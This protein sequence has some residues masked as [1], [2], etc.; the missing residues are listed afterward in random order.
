M[1]PCWKPMALTWAD[2]APNVHQ[3]DFAGTQ[4][5][6]SGR[7]R[8]PSLILPLA[9]PSVRPSRRKRFPALSAVIAF[10]VMHATI[11]AMIGDFGAPDLS[12]ATASVLGINSLQMGVFGGIIVGLGTAA[13]LQPAFTRFSFRRCS[14]GFFSGTRFVPIISAA[15]STGGWASQCIISGR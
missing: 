10:F 9:S 13:L 4:R 2:G 11:G 14:H 12:G 8:Y 7:V 3:R 6:R 5:G 15:W 1:K